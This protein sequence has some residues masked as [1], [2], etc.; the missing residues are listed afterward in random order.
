VMVVEDDPF[1]RAYAISCLESMG[2]RVTPADNAREAERLLVQ[3]L[4]ID[5]IF[6][7]VVMPGGMSGWD[8][9]AR[10]R[11][12]RPGIKVLLTSGHPLE[13]LQTHSRAV[14]TE[15]ILNKPYRKAELARRVRAVLDAP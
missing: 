7:D 2:Y 6:S 1:V 12:L 4:A 9:A 11:D 8:L 3:G 14:A 10:A 5:L 13:T 15:A